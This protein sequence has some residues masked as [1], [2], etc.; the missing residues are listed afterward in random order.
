MARCGRCGSKYTN[1][2]ENNRCA[3]SNDGWSRDSGGGASFAAAP[4]G[5]AAGIIL[6]AVIAVLR[7]SAITVTAVSALA[8]VA[9]LYGCWRCTRVPQQEAPAGSRE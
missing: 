3:N 5:I 4:Q 1:G 8:V 7:P 2:C 9:V 6:T